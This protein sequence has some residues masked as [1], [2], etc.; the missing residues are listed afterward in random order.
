MIHHQYAAVNS[1]FYQAYIMTCRPQQQFGVKIIL[2]MDGALLSH[3]LI[4]LKKLKHVLVTLSQVHMQ[5]YGELL[6]MYY[7]DYIILQCFT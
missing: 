5:N 7:T 4:P 1:I 2:L 6:I 3:G